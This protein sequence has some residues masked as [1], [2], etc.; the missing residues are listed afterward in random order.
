MLEVS[1]MCK[2]VRREIRSMTD[3]DRNGFFEALRTYFDVL[4]TECDV[5]ARKHGFVKAFASMAFVTDLVPGVVMTAIFAQ[6]HLL[7]APLRATFGNE[8]EGVEQLS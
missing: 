3:A 2:Y 1:V 5:V 6:M 8:D 4:R 7:A